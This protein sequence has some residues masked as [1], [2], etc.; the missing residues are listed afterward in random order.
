MARTP[1]RYHQLYDDTPFIQNTADLLDHV[2]CDCGSSHSLRMDVL[3][4]EEISITY[5][6]NKSLTK[7]ARTYNTNGRLVSPK[8]LAQL[9]EL[10]A[11]LKKGKKKKAHKLWV[12]MWKEEQTFQTQVYSGDFL[13]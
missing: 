1:A 5:F 13:G 8:F 6:K 7:D 3:N 11:L 2:C 9:K 10:G 12:S 4:S